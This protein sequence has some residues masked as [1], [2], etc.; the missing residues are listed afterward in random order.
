MKFA[1]PA[2]LRH[3]AAILL[4]AL[5][6][7]VAAAERFVIE[8]IRIEGLQRVSAG[9][10]FSALPVAVRDTVDASGLARLGRALFPTGNF[11]DVQV[12]RDGNVLVVRVQ[13]RPSI[14]EINIS[15]N[16]VLETK[17]LLK[18]LQSAGLAEGQVFK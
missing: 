1:C 3:L 12:G 8:D 13:E 18:A 6:G 14:S 16:K 15:G 7:T 5:T 2:A 4:L 9:L 10:V 17:S 11:D